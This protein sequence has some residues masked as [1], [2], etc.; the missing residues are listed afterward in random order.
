MF[1][2]FIIINSFSASLNM[3]NLVIATRIALPHHKH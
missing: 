2:V 3:F 1:A